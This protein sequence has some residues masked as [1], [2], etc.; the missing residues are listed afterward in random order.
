MPIPHDRAD[1]LTRVHA[2]PERSMSDEVLYLGTVKRHHASLQ[3]G[4]PDDEV[5]YLGTVNRR[6]GPD[7]ASRVGDPTIQN[8]AGGRPTNRRTKARTGAS[9]SRATS[10]LKRPSHRDSISTALPSQPRRQSRAP[11]R[12]TKI[13]LR[14]VDRL[15]KLGWSR[16]S[17]GGGRQAVYGSFSHASCFCY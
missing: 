16:R 3:N 4:V 8:T 5:V 15:V 13:P 1:R 11:R 7:E 10:H 12:Q 9:S 14:L 6:H 17:D 2:L